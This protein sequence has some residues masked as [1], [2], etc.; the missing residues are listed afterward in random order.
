[1]ADIHALIRSLNKT[2]GSDAISSADDVA[3]VFM[4]RSNIPAYDY[5]TTG[6]FPVG[7]IIEHYGDA[8]NGFS[9]GKSAVAY[10]ALAEF[11][12]TCW[13]TRTQ[14]AFRNLKFEAAKKGKKDD[15]IGELKALTGHTM[16]RG[17]KGEPKYKY[18]ALIEPEA[19]FTPEW[20]EHWGIENGGLI[21]MRPE[22]AEHAVNVTEALLMNEDVSLVVF[23]SMSIVGAAAESD[24]DMESQQM[25]LNAR[26]WNKAV[27][28][29]Q[30]AMNKNPSHD[31][32]LLLINSAG[33]KIGIAYGDPES[34]KN[35]GQLKLSKSM[36]V[37][38]RSGKTIKGVDEF[39]S[40]EI[41]K[42]VHIENKKNKVGQ[43]G[44][45]ADMFYLYVAD[46][47]TE[48]KTFDTVA[49]LIELGLMMGFISRKGAFYTYEKTT[50]QG[51]N[52]F[53]LALHGKD[54]LGKLKEDVYSKIRGGE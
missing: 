7:R 3:E 14:G 9:C 54:M 48:A 49:Q 25:G 27:R 21:H 34:I 15:T 26:F 40:V 16:R 39:A 46:E 22:T 19:T 44:L 12:H 18:V 10:R 1:M 30:S 43:E 29:F 38:F 33:L 23:D 5:V 2:I 51:L 17:Y 28:K 47:I 50:G 6:G 32:T 41:G 45:E 36:S 24:S 31:C 4:I 42:N 37:K 35:G 13:N 20:G 8:V 53:K 11:Q 52:N